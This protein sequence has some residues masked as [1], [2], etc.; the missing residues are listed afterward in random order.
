VDNEI[1]IRHAQ[2]D[3][4]VFRRSIVDFLKDESN[5]EIVGEAS[6]FAEVLELTA[7]QK[8]DVL[9][10]DVYMTDGKVC[11]RSQPLPSARSILA[12]SLWN[13]NETKELGTN[14]SAS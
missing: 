9:L 8:P 12:M 1:T 13:D 14:L 3:S 6:S 11:V 5:I 7:A 2:D 4:E 10:M